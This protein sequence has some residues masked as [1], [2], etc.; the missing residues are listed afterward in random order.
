MKQRVSWGIMFLLSIILIVSGF[1]GSVG[2]ILACI[3]T[4]SEVTVNQGVE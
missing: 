1:Q 2:K 4:P 3:F